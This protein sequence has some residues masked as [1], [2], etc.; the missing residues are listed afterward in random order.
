LF[1]PLKSVL[2]R[3]RATL[4]NR[5]E[6]AYADRDAEG[7]TASSRSFAAGEARAYG[8]AEADVRAAQTEHDN[9]D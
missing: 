1:D 4:A 8:R 5:T 9:E 2:E 7:V 6:Q 3:L